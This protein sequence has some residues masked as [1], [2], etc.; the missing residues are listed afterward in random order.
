MVKISRGSKI[1]TLFFFLTITP[2]SC[3][4]GC[5]ELLTKESNKQNNQ[6]QAHE[7]WTGQEGHIAHLPW[8]LILTFHWIPWECSSRPDSK[9]YCILGNSFAI[10]FF[11]LKLQLINFKC[12]LQR[13]WI[14]KIQSFKI[15]RLKTYW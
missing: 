10:S 2:K 7:M 8:P 3:I 9:H 14:K 6:T 13:R 12:P 1:E 11:S 5:L 4:W 15:W